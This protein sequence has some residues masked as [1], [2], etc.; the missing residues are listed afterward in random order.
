LPKANEKDLVEL[1][2]SVRAEM[3]FVFAERIEEAL[4]AAIPALAE[5]WHEPQPTQT[6]DA[7]S[8]P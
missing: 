6:I 2:P 3:E 1:P 4:Q 8:T 5:R 7:A